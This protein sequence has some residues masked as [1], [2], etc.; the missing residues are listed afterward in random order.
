MRK[1]FLTKNQI[2]KS[3]KSETRTVPF[4]PHLLEA[5]NYN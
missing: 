3:C 2:K 5:L 1:N 4:L